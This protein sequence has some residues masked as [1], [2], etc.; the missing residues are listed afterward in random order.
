M[1]DKATTPRRQRRS[2]VRPIP[3]V[4]VTEEM[5]TGADQ[6]PR[7]G[8]ATG[9]KLDVNSKL[10]HF[11]RENGWAKVEHVA[12]HAS[13]ELDGATVTAR[14]GAAWVLRQ[15]GRMV[16]GTGAKALAEALAGQVAEVAA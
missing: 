12:D 16:E 3:P 9:K 1:I 7:P 4:P 14:R 13:W 10:S 11:F 8:A 15:D 6:A 5:A 2:R